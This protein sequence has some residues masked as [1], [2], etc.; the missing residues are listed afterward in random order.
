VIRVEREIDVPLAPERLWPVLWDVPRMVACMPGCSEA[1]EVEAH[2]RYEARMS[3]RVGPISL[4][5]SMEVTITDALEPS[6]LRLEAKGRDRL[7]GAN[8]AMTVALDVT[9]R[10]GGS[11]VRLEA[12]GKILGKLG[13]LGQG[14]IQRKA[15]E[16]IDDFGGRLREVVTT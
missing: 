3:Q 1:R 2:R 10:G 5:A 7:L 6:R 16:M 4:S 12:E 8:I 13:A 9:P 11:R 15:E 14:V